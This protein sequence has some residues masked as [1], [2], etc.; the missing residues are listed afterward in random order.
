MNRNAS[1]IV[2]LVGGWVDGYHDAGWE[3]VKFHQ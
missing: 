1:V 3:V 2:E